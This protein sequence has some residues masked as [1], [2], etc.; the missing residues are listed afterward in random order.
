MDFDAFLNHSQF[1][2][3]DPGYDNRLPLYFLYSGLAKEY[4]P[5]SGGQKI[6]RFISAN[7]LL[8]RLDIRHGIELM[9]DSVVVHITFSNIV[10]MLRLYPETSILHQKIKQQ[11]LK[12][13]AEFLSAVR[14]KT[15]AERYF[16]LL[17]KQPEVFEF[18]EAGEIASYLNISE[19]QYQQLLA[20]N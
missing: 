1:L 5:Q 14:Q 20:V 10:K 7:Q 11:Y 8:L 12:E 4:I 2:E 15:T 16:D 3:Q 9:E 18:A 13:R 19:A 17:E 6:V